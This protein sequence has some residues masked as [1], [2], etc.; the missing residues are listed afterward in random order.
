MTEANEPLTIP[1]EPY[2]RFGDDLLDALLAQLSTDEGG[3]RRDALRRALNIDTATSNEVRLEHVES[4]LT[5]LEAYTDAMREFFDENGT[6]DDVLEAVQDGLEAA[7]TD[8]EAL[9]SNVTDLGASDE[10]L[11]ERVDGLEETLERLDSRL[12]YVG[13]ET[14]EL[15]GDF[16]AARDSLEDSVAEIGA[17]TD[18]LADG[19]EAQFETVQ[20]LDARQE[21][22]TDR[23]DSIAAQR[24][25]DRT[26]LEARIDERADEL[27]ERIDA[28]E[29]HV[30]DR[31]ASLR[32]DL[33]AEL[34]SVDASLTEDVEELE[35]HV[36][37]LE[38]SVDDSI[39]DVRTAVADDLDSLESDLGTFETATD[40]R[41]DDLRC[42][43]E[44]DLDDLEGRVDELE[45]TAAEA[46]EWRQSLQHAFQ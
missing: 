11:E 45:A 7:R 37:D 46:E 21:D 19:L 12:E 25:A 18:T 4:S 14:A 34:E 24:E 10:V 15:R 38:K 17:T 43:L 1:D 23:L 33:F 27:E 6:A 3:A 32:E 22:L 40:E 26:A 9:E 5:E 29:R 35:T 16:E 39:A 13:T 41:I 44:T 36:S 20:N 2:D 8:L 31:L 30:D 28:V 42:A